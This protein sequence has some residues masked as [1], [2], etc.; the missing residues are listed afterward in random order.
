MVD[1]TKE[2]PYENL[3]TLFVSLTY[4]GLSI[5]VLMSDWC[6]YNQNGMAVPGKCTYMK[7]VFQT[8]PHLDSV[9]Q[10]LKRVQQTDENHGHL[11]MT[12][13]EYFPVTKVNSVPNGATPFCRY[14]GYNVLSVTRWEHDTLDNYKYGRDTTRELTSIISKGQGELA[15]YENTGYGNYGWFHLTTTLVVANIIASDSDAATETNG[16][17]RSKAECLY[18]PNYQRMQ[19][20]KKKYDPEI[21][22]DKWFV[23]TPAA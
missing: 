10:V 3:N 22:F 5:L 20:I 1:M 2:I 23:I 8:K 6:P 18:G 7:G 15:G 21:V 17:S 14:P 9:R 19:Q 12:L 11:S 13:F 4:R 16:T